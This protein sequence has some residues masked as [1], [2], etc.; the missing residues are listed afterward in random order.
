[1]K[2]VF[3]VE[4]LKEKSNETYVDSVWENKEDAQ[5]WVNEMNEWERSENGQGDW[6]FIVEIDYHAK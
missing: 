5:K 2:E 3:V 1:M 4:F 6:W